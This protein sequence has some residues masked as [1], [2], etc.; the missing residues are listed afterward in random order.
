MSPGPSSLNTPLT[1][2][3]FGTPFKNLAASRA[4]SKAPSAPVVTCC[5]MAGL[6]VS[7]SCGAGLMRVDSYTRNLYDTSMPRSGSKEQGN[8]R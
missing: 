6:A 4:I 2:T 1:G 7:R 5:A 8:A 3:R